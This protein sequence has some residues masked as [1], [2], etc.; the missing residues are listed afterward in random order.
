MS[1]DDLAERPRGIEC[2]TDADCAHENVRRFGRSD[3]VGNPVIERQC[4]DCGA[5]VDEGGETA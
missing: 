2:N 3:A 5:Y 4:V 1:A